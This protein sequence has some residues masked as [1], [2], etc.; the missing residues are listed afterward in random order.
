MGVDFSTVP[1]D[2]S[3]ALLSLLGREKLDAQL[4][5]SPIIPAP[6]PHRGTVFKDMEGTSQSSGN[7][8]EEA[9][10]AVEAD[11]HRQATILEP[12]STDPPLSI[13]KERV[14]PVEPMRVRMEDRSKPQP[15]NKFY[16]NLML[17]D[18]HAPIWTHPYGLRWDS[19]G[20]AQQGISI[21]HVDDS[22]KTFGPLEHLDASGSESRS[23]KFYLNPFLIN[24]GLSAT[25]L[26]E[27]HDMTVGD[28][29][30]FSCTVELTPS[31]EWALERQDRPGS[32]LRIPVVRGMAFISAVYKD[33]TPQFY[34]NI[35]IRKLTLDPQPMADGWVKYRF[36][37]E[38][39]VTWLLYAKPDR[40]GDASLRLEMREQGQAVASS[41]RFTGL[42]QIAKLPVDKEDETER[43]YDKAMGVYPTEGELLIRRRYVDSQS[44]GYRID[45]KLAGDTTKQFIHFTLPHHRDVLTDKTMPT[46]LVL[47]STS[48]GKMVAYIGSSWHLYESERVVIDFLPEGWL[49]TVQPGQLAAIKSQARADIE[50]NFDKETDL[51]SMY[52]AGKG[53][54]KFA[55]LCLVVKDVLN[56]TEE[57]QRKCL[58]KLK[59]SFARYMENR[60][61]FPLVYD[62][63]WRGLVSVQGLNHGAL[64]DFGNS[65]YND[66][67]YHYGY[68]IHAAAIFRHLDPDWRTEELGNYVDD[69]L[70]D[71]A[72]PSSNDTHFPRFRSFDWFMG[73]SWSQGIFV[74]MDG[75]DEES[76]SEDINLYYAMSLWGRVSNRPEMDQLGQMMLTI[77]RRSIQAY[78]LLEDDNMN[79]P[80]GF[81]G[82]KVT[83]ILYENKVDHTTFFS[84]RIECIQG[85]QMIP[86]TPALPM[87]RR[88]EFVKQEWE[89][90]LQARADEIDDGWK[91]ILMM[92]YGT[93]DKAGAWKY[94]AESARPVQLDDGMTL[95]WAMFYVASLASHS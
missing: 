66:H 3:D 52:F 62:R 94:F 47:P 95:T 2:P 19:I 78:F 54:A 71:V 31:S 73:H 42:V 34:S 36:L 24:M 43:V 90:Q 91:S 72:N 45:W 21:S 41:R 50:H 9:A 81:I 63:I 59:G 16:G 79:H 55:L 64:A 20:Q 57:V 80:P 40:S 6:I 53:L 88:K 65:W 60:Q 22:F 35:L 85:I 23:A 92:N 26:D 77:A 67:H 49:Q 51:D 18:S 93:L 10:A 56:D 13:F 87:I 86:A 28:F 48:K 83:G 89:R 69:L 58:D 17:G 44:G 30:E 33:L 76:T 68:F 4:S 38:N 37:I 32:F 5:Q 8:T 27:H 25:E 39:G 1:L 74:S 15:T 61:K 82:N 46:A 11:W 70:R 29:G 75:K 14:H 84:P 12:I 7:T